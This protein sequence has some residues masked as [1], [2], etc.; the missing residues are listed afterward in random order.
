MLKSP[1]GSFI[2]AVGLFAVAIGAMACDTTV[3]N[4]AAAPK[5]GNMVNQSLQVE[6]RDGKVLVHYT[7]DNQSPNVVHVPV[8]IAEDDQLF[9]SLFVITDSATGKPLEYTGPMVKRGPITAD[10]FLAVKP[11]TKHG[12]TIDI[13]NSYAFRQG[14][15]SYRL[16][17][18]GQY[19]DD[20]RNLEKVT[21]AALAPVQFSH[22][23]K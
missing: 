20:V 13:T 14:T 9:A 15:H 1:S 22:T 3:T 2:N 6:S 5:A 10:D 19:L 12:N 16:A 11:K 4:S 23:V 21:P 18:E 8:S 7:I 17:Y